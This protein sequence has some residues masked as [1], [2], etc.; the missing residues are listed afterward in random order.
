MSHASLLR[1]NQQV[2]RHLYLAREVAV[3]YSRRT[4]HDKDDLRQVGLLPGLYATERCEAFW[5]TA[6]LAQHDTSKQDDLVL[7]A[8]HCLDACR[9][10]L[11]ATA[12]QRYSCSP[13]QTTSKSGDIG[14]TQLRDLQ[15]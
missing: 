6:P 1:S 14:S 7:N 3:R 4:G 13:G 5:A 2:E 10:L 11:M 12:D 8:D 9:Y 15:H